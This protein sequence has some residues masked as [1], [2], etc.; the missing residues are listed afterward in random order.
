MGIDCLGFEKPDQDV[1]P[2]SRISYPTFS[3]ARSDGI[4]AWEVLVRVLRLLRA[5]LNAT[6]FIYYVIV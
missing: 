5:R 6:T 4:V 3:V 2:I 1:Q